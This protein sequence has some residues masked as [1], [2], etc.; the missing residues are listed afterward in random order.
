MDGVPKT[1]AESI[2]MIRRKQKAKIGWFKYC[3]AMPIYLHNWFIKQQNRKS[4]HY[5]VI[6]FFNNNKLKLSRKK[7]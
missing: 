6:Y 1:K 2:Q 7:N 3:G 5:A 4:I